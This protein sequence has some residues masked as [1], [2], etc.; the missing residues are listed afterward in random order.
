MHDEDELSS[1]LTSLLMVGTTVIINV[2]QGL[3]LVSLYHMKRNTTVNVDTK[4]RLAEA[5]EMTL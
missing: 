4:V 2:N 5:W 3:L 1:S